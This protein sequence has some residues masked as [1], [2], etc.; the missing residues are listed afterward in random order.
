MRFISVLSEI[1]V[2][3]LIVGFIKNKPIAKVANS[4]GKRHTIS[5]SE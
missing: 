3:E 5:P 2:P 1:G 4:Y